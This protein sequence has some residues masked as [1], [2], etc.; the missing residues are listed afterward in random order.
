METS[1]D[2]DGVFVTV[3]TRVSRRSVEVD[4]SGQLR[5]SPCNVHP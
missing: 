4:V 2:N 1:Y 3:M 5:R